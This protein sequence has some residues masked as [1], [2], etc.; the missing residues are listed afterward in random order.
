MKIIYQYHN[1]YPTSVSLVKCTTGQLCLWLRPGNEWSTGKKVYVV[2][3]VDKTYDSW[4]LDFNFSSAV[5]TL[6][7]W[8]GDVTELPPQ[9]GTMWRITNKCY[10][11]V[12]YGCQCLEVGMILRYEKYLDPSFTLDFNS[13]SLDLCTEPPDC[14][15]TA[16][17]DVTTDSSLTT[18]AECAYL[19][20]LEGELHCQLEAQ[21]TELRLTGTAGSG[22]GLEPI[23]CLYSNHPTNSSTLCDLWCQIVLYI[24][25]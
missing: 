15:E 5:D 9:D 23:P 6:E 22:S 19:G 1:S 17:A 7:A 13:I 10:N 14:D 24:L 12:L 18:A 4:T 2:I 21:L 20:M 16:M 25:Y 3:P 8:K 11:G